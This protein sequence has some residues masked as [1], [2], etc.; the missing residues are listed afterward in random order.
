MFFSNLFEAEFDKQKNLLTP[1]QINLVK[2]H[3]V[4]AIAD[5]LK[6]MLDSE[7]SWT[8][9]EIQINRWHMNKDKRIKLLSQSEKDWKSTTWPFSDCFG[10]TGG[11]A[12]YHK[13]KTTDLESGPITINVTLTNNKLDWQEW[14]GYSSGFDMDTLHL[15]TSITEEQYTT[16]FRMIRNFSF[17]H[18]VKT[19][20][21][22]WV[23]DISEATH[24][25]FMKYFK[26]QGFNAEFINHD[27][28]GGDNHTTIQNFD[29]D[30]YKTF[31]QDMEESFQL[32]V[33]HSNFHKSIPHC[34]FFELL[35]KMIKDNIYYDYEELQKMV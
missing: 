21:N 28:I 10:E 24:V 32:S 1:S 3:I 31:D 34:Q 19:K 25:K 18:S 23:K 29:W 9:P 26:S 13:A 30:N 2:E 33:Q 27:A 17:K 8:E 22:F 11:W 15:Q 7:C 14:H 35:F 20:L 4:P 6:Q 5:H 12:K 16:L